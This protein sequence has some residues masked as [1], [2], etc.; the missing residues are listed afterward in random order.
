MVEF[1]NRI[2]ATP[3]LLAA[4]VAMWICWRL[5]GPRRRDLRLA[6]AITVV[7]VLLQ[8]VVGAMTVILELPPE[9]VSAHFLLSVGCI[10]AATV[11]WHATGSAEPLRISG[12]RGGVRAVAAA[13]MLLSL[14]AVIVAGVL[15]TASGPHS[16]AAG[17]GQQVD[18]LD[19]FS[20]AVT[21]HARGAY[22]FLALVLLL[23]WAR[24]ARGVALRD[25]GLLV[26]LVAGQ[27]ALGELQYRS[28]LPWQVVLAHV[29]NA[30]LMWIVAVR[31]AADAAMSATP[32][33]TS[34]PGTAERSE[35]DVLAAAR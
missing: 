29:A 2:T 10:A 34:P 24:R 15:T 14:L 12:R 18:R 21:L 16:G 20:L 9:I 7:G 19:L 8:A 26:A 5:S 11:A 28:G 25:L 1:M 30:A 4:L 22:A 35:R 27:V 31:I 33:P 13:L 32:D 6:T 17:T 3:T 23:T